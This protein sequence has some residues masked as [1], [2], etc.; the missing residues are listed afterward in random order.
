MSVGL[1]ALLDD[2]AAIA[3]AAAA[4]LDDIAAAS[5]KASA[6]AAGVVVDDAAVTPQYVAGIEPS[7]ELPI[8]WK[9]ARG[10]IINKVCIILPVALLLSQYL[11]WMLQPLL[12]LG[13]AFLC[14]EGAHKVIE[15][16]SGHHTER[17]DPAVAGQNQQD[18]KAITSGAIRTDLILSAEIMVIALNEVADQPFWNRLI[19]LIVV[20]ILITAVVY[21]AVALL[22]K[23]D[24]IG[25][26][27]VERGRKGWKSFGQWLVRIMPT[28]F[29]FISLVGTI[30]MLWVGG[31]LIL[32]GMHEL[33]L[34]AP[35]DFVHYLE[36]FGAEVPGA[37]GVLA[38]CINTLCSLIFGF[39]VG[40]II[41]GVVHLLPFGNTDESHDSA[42]VAE[43]ADAA[44]TSTAITAADG[45]TR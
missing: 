23:I 21:G 20:A 33:G 8:I 24:D 31:H 13:G 36:H 15:K 4:S 32:V 11:P 18:E 35:Y 39:A 38:W 30:A 1:V 7:R 10:S 28:V 37:G 9:I 3:R 17:E 26:G 34:T 25:L 44:G 22:V 41:V 40:A 6:K 27:M 2:I 45:V 5:L 29:D 42:N 43:A 19:I 12:M 14:F 16:L